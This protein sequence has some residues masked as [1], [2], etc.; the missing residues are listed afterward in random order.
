MFFRDIKIIGEYVF[1]KDYNPWKNRN[2]WHSGFS[3]DLI[4]QVCGNVNNVVEFGSYDAGDGIRY[5]Y[6]FPNSN[7]YSIEASPACYHKIKPLEKYGLKIFN[8]AVTNK[9]GEIDF[10][11]TYDDVLDNYAPCGA[12]ERDLVSTDA[13]SK[14]LRI[15]PPI[16]V[17]CITLETF[18]K[19]QGIEYIDLLHVDVEGHDLQA[20]EGMGKIRAKI[21]FIEVTGGPGGTHDH[22]QQM[23]EL[24][25]SMTFYIYM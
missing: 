8:Y 20:I 11:G 4:K 9:N 24:M 3:I 23:S 7:V 17:P 22:S 16:K 13:G 15:L 1:I 10:H 12:I 19:N 6:Y 14:T 25:Y 2:L 21:I 18:C 5:K